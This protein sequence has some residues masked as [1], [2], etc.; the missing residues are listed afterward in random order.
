MRKKGKPAT[1]QSSRRHRAAAVPTPP[2]PPPLP[3]PPLEPNLHYLQRRMSTERT[4][5]PS[6]HPH[7]SQVHSFDTSTS[8]THHTW[9]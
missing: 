1:G 3:T 2:S 9:P 8:T 4:I 6:D 7:I 5:R